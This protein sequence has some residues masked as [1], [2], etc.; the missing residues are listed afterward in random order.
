MVPAESDNLQFA[1]SVFIFLD[2]RFEM[3][4]TS[5]SSSERIAWSTCHAVRRCGRT[6]EPMVTSERADGYCLFESKG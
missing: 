6:T 2:L 5:L 4:T 1:M 3:R